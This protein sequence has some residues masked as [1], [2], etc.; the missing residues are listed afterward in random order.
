MRPER[1]RLIID[2]EVA[3]PVRASVGA[4]AWFVL[5]AVAFDAP[6]GREAVEM[7]CTS[8][9]LSEHLGMSKDSAARALR[10]L[11]AAGIVERTDYRD[12]RSGRFGS[13]IYVIDFGA[14]G[15]TVEAVSPLP[16]TATSD[17]AEGDPVLAP[18][19]QSDSQLSLLP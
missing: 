9:R 13:S 16:D 7:E 2:P 4:T 12:P 14:A 8:R 15:L 5:E 19:E 3:A 17:I 10:R 6:T 18:A 1:R 11:A